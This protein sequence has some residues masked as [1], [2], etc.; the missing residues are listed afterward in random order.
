M[1]LACYVDLRFVDSHYNDSVW[2]NDVE[3]PSSE[4]QRLVGVSLPAFCEKHGHVAF[5]A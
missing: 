2:T 3:A 4:D 1:I 5:C